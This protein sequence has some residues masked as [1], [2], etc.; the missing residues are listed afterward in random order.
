MIFPAAR[1]PGE[2]ETSAMRPTSD[3]AWSTMQPNG[4]LQPG[5]APA[6]QSQPPAAR[7]TEGDAARLGNRGGL[8]NLAVVLRENRGFGEE[9]S[10]LARG[11]LRIES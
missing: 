10:V 7:A 8:P 6:F 1:W 2:A 9:R 5:H 3:K 4:L 11:K